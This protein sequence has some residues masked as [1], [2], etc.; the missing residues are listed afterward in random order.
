MTRTLSPRLARLEAAMQPKGGQVHVVMVPRGMLPDEESAWRDREKAAR[1]IHPADT[2][3]F[4][5]LRDAGDPHGR[6]V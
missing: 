6:S 4:V 3:I 5:T 1:G 2:A